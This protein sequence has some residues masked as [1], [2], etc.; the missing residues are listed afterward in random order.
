MLPEL[1]QY[2]HTTRTNFRQ[3]FAS[4]LT[5]APSDQLDR[6]GDAFD[7]LNQRKSS[8]IEELREDSRVS[9]KSGDGLGAIC[10][11]CVES[12]VTPILAV[13]GIETE[14]VARQ[15]PSEWRDQRGF[16]L[17]HAYNLL[18]HGPF[19][20]VVDLDADPFYGADTGVVVAPLAANVPIYNHGFVYHMRSCA[21]GGGI[22]RFSCVLFDDAHGSRVYMDGDGAEYISIAPYQFE[23]G[24][25]SCPL[26]LAGGAT[27][28]FGYDKTWDT[29]GHVF[30]SISLTCVCRVP[31][32]TTALYNLGFRRI[33]SFHVRSADDRKTAVSIVFEDTSQFEVLIASDG[34][35]LPNKYVKIRNS[36]GIMPQTVSI[37]FMENNRTPLE[38]P[39]WEHPTPETSELGSYTDVGGSN[40]A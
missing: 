37:R 28:Y 35:L 8:L 1:T 25:N 7:A 14:I 18:N 17:M 31:I 3:R 32:C 27:L 20:F 34:S 15:Y 23:S 36:S 30:H 39:F 21:S 33:H 13:F 19:C 26:V 5:G 22:T 16:P 38:L 40:N 29:R 9:Y 4:L 10:I 6:F 2:V 24:A 12:H 11:S